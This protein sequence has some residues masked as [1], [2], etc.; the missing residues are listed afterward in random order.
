MKATLGLLVLL[1]IMSA[2]AQ[3]KLYR[4][5]DENGE[6]HYSDKVPPKA[7]QG[8]RDVLNERGLAVETQNRAKTAAEIEAE[9]QAKLAE[10]Q[11]KKEQELQAR[12]DRVL[13]QTFSS[14]RELE[15]SRDERVAAINSFITITDEKIADYQSR[16]ANFREQARPYNEK[17][18]PVPQMLNK[19][20]ESL[21]RQLSSNQDFV[22]KK[23]AE[24]EA[25]I[26]KF[27]SD[28]ARFKELQALKAQ[29]EAD[30]SP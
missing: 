29:R 13:Q 2:S 12:Q 26:K 16:L 19:N 23:E 18:N 24:R 3:A 30:A 11:R 6:V 4:W 1:M 10:E 22:K 20:I 21:E 9:R 25:L 5:V 28:I 15:V 8:Q 17:G 7:S 14:L 27:E